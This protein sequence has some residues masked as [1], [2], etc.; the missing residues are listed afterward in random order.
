[1]GY[2][3]SHFVPGNVPV[4]LPVGTVQYSTATTVVVVSSLGKE[5]RALIGPW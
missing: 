5:E 2:T 1:M 4:E 3:V